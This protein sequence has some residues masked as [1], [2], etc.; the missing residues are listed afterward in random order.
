MKLSKNSLMTE[1][2]RSETLKKNRFSIS[3]AENWVFVQ[4]LEIFRTKTLQSENRPILSK[5]EINS[6]CCEIEN[7][8]TQYECVIES[9]N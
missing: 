1:R 2:P 8:K 4:M 6:I 5:E 3:N 9:R 7:G